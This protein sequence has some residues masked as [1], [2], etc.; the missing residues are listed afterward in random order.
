MVFSQFTPTHDSVEPAFI[1][2]FTV[3]IIAT[4][5]GGSR[6]AVNEGGLILV[7]ENAFL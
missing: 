1:I 4:E 5:I 3:L 7:N 2:V 6:Q